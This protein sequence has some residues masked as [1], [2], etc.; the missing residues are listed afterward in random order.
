M[1]Y[2]KMADEVSQKVLSYLKD[3]SGWKLAKSSGKITVSW[4]PSNEFSGNLYRGEGIIE[5][6]PEKII[7]FLYSDEHR[8]KW[9]K[10]LKFYS[11]LEHIDQDTVIGHT[12]THSYGMGLISSREF[13]DLIH[14]RRYDGGVVTTNSVSLEYEKCPVTSDR[15]RGFNN[16]CGY[17]CSPLPENPAHSKL[18]VFIQT[19]LGGLL[20]R[21]LVE[22]ALPSNIIGLITNVR[23]GTKKFV[24]DGK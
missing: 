14:I 22:S 10:D 12:I 23:E 2:K 13:V 19:E 4:K 17:I 3:D 1:D 5:E 21:A 16:P 9:D 18:V 15:I 6:V 24:Q 7:P 8:K 20:P 11:I